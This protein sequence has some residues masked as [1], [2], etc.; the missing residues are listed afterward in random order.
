MAA[1]DYGGKKLA[2]HAV[3]ALPVLVDVVPHNCNLDAGRGW[4][5]AFGPATKAVIVSHLHGGLVPMTKA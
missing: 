2:V 5:D 1:Y 4:S 3:E